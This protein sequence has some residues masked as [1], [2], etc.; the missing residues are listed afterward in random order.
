MI[1][2]LSLLLIL[3]FVLGFWIVKGS[4]APFSIKVVSI[5]LFFSFCVMMAATLDSSMGWSAIGKPGKNIPEIVTIRNI[6]IREPNPSLSFDGSIYLLLDMTENKTDS[7]L[8][9]LFGHIPEGVE[10]RLYRLPYSR[11]LH[12]QLQKSVIPR[13]LKGQTVTGRLK[14]GPRGEDEG[15]GEFDGEGDGNGHGR[16]GRGRNGQGPGGNGNGGD[17][18]DTEFHFYNLPPSE[19][20]P[21]IRSE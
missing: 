20:I 10:P 13:L 19:L 11:S 4:P 14:K 5:T 9:R 8:L 12:E 17:N 6:V 1:T 15:E 21:K 7:T 16:S 2:T 3:L 18:R